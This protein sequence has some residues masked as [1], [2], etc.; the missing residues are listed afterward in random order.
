MLYQ[1]FPMQCLEELV[2]TPIVK[3]VL[4]KYMDGMTSVLLSLYGI[5]QNL[6]RHAAQHAQSMTTW[7]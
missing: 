5:V 2:F 3:N 1:M 4:V 7:Q 6:T